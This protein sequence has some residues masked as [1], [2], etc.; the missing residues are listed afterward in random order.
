MYVALHEVTWR[1]VDWFYTEL[2]PR[3]QQFHVAAAMPAL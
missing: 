1:M 2:V 3:W